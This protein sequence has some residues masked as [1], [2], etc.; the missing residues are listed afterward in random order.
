MVFQNI[1]H[2]FT[3]EDPGL[4]CRD[5]E[6]MPGQKRLCVFLIGLSMSWKPNMLLKDFMSV[7]RFRGA[8]HV[9]Q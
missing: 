4:V 1:L 7:I 8:L 6:I 5:T 2:V 9:Q 3:N